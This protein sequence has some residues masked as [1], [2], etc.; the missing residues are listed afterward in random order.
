MLALL[1]WPDLAPATAPGES[2]RD[3]LRSGELGPEMVVV[4]AG[5]FLMGDL[6][7]GG[8]SGE[9]PVHEVTISQPFAIGKYEIT[10]EDYQR[11][12]GPSAPPR[13]EGWGRGNRPVINVSWSE[14]V[15]YVSWLS[16][17]T[18]QHYRLLS[19]AEWEYAARAGTTTAFSWGDHAGENLAN[20]ASCG[21]PPWGGKQ[22][23]PVGSFPANPWGLFDMHGNVWEWVRDCANENYNGA[24]SDGS[25]W[26]AGDCAERMVR[27]GAFDFGAKLS[28]SSYR[29]S[30]PPDVSHPFGFR[31]ARD[32]DTPDESAPGE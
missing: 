15:A 26:E 9:R 10:F 8:M 4:P 12:L 29:L 30:L 17:E 22:S 13:D 20:C 23:A 1:A 7:G 11:F 28:R 5:R 24:P 25:A 27:G 2:F 14:A 31:V 6:L 3:F 32:L 21:S 19:E 16:A 18:G